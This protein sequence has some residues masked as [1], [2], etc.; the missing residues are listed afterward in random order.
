MTFKIVNL[1][2]KYK[3]FD[4]W[5]TLIKINLYEKHI[6]WSIQL[7][8]YTK[9]EHRNWPWTKNLIWLVLTQHSTKKKFSIKGFF[10]KCD[11]IRRKLWIWS[12]LLKKSL[13][14]NFNFWEVQRIEFQLKASGRR[15]TNDHWLI[16]RQSCHH[17]ETSQS[18][19]TDWFLIWWQLWHLM[20]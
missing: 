15:R 10:S 5:K 9:S 16:K 14:E 3:E 18:K 11:Q 2:S 13:M 8:A 12:H 7:F 6:A 19:S 17:I 4:Q 20:S 1:K